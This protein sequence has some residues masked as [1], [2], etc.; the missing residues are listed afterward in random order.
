VFKRAAAL[1]REAVEKEPDHP[2]I[3]YHL[4]MAYYKDGK[5]EMAKLELEK[6]LELSKEF[7]GA[8]EV[9]EVLEKLKKQ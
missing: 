8:E 1:I 5:K 9:R 3:R 4:G 2:V 7:D 6:S